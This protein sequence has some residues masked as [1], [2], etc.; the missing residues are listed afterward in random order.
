M[1]RAFYS[2]MPQDL[3]LGTSWHGISHTYPL[4]VG[5]K[6]NAMTT[7]HNPQV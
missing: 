7:E 2:L 4:T 5:K 6:K 1:R 3:F